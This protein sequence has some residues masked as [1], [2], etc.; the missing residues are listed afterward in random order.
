[1]IPSRKEALPMAKDLLL[2]GNIIGLHRKA[3]EKLSPNAIWMYNGPQG[4]VNSTGHDYIDIV[5]GRPKSMVKDGNI[6][7][8]MTLYSKLVTYKGI[9]MNNTTVTARMKA[10]G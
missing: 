7:R 8:A 5:N 10:A 2:P 9:D 6:S 4:L 1:M 3:V